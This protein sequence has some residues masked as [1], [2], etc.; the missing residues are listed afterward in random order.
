MFL[1][2][3][4]ALETMLV[5]SFK[6]MTFPRATIR[7]IVPRHKH[8]IIIIIKRQN[9]IRLSFIIIIITITSIR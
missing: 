1:K 3:L 2:Q 7:P 6:N 9:F 5:L 8:S 4:F